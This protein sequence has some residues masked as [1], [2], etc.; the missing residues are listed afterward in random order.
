MKKLFI[1]LLLTFAII[2][3]TY[4]APPARVYTYIT[5]EIIEASKNTANED[6]IF[7]YLQT[8]IDTIA[9]SAVTTT[10][11]LDGTIANA[12]ISGT[13]A[14]T[15]GKLSLGSSL[16]TGDIKDG[17]IVNADLSSS[18]AIADSKLAATDLMKYANTRFIVGTFTRDLTV[19]AGNVTISGVGFTPKAVIFIGAVS[20]SVRTVCWGQDDGTT[21]RVLYQAEISDTF[22]VVGTYSLWVEPAGNNLQQAS[23]SSFNS[24][25]FVL[26]WV[27]TNSPTGTL[28]VNYIAFR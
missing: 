3:V 28:T 11:I 15:Y 25:G 18:A 5:G 26:T 23:I 22:N 7:R 17:E 14:I 2:K 4:S 19:A 1:F 12:D 16:L 13:A 24:D 20:G 8:G 10:H 21:P 27:K 9:A 6:A